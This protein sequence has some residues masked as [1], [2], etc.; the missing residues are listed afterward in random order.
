MCVPQYTLNEQDSVLPCGKAPYWKEHLSI[1]QRLS[2]IGTL[3]VVEWLLLQQQR[4]SYNL[5][6]HPTDTPCAVH[7]TDC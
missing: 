6:H 3:P 5:L 2:E 1:S 4:Q 7:P